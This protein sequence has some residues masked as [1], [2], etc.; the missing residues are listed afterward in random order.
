MKLEESENSELG[1][2]PSTSKLTQR[3]E[4]G[5]QNKEVNRV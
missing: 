1:S 4:E 2:L 3:H 5:K